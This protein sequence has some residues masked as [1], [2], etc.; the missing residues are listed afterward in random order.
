MVKF[1]VRAALA[2]SMFSI[3]GFALAA[4]EQ[5]RIAFG[6]KLCT[7]ALDG[8][9]PALDIGDAG[10][11]LAAS[12]LSRDDFC[13]CVGQAY[14]A[15]GKGAHA[16]V[17][18][19][20]RTAFVSDIAFG[21][22]V[23]ERM[24]ACLPSEPEDGDG[25]FSMGE[26]FFANIANCEAVVAGDLPMEGL[27]VGALMADM[28]KMSLASEQLCS[29][30][31]HYFT[32]NF[33]K[34]SADIDA[35]S[36]EGAAYGHHMVTAIS[37]CRDLRG[38]WPETA[39]PDPAIDPDA[40]AKDICLAVANRTIEP[41]GFDYDYLEVWKKGSGLD[42]DDLCTCAAGE[43]EARDDYREEREAAD[44]PEDKR[45]SQILTTATDCFRIMWK[46]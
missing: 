41:E 26:A 36:Q 20:M 27:N 46:P 33:D 15:E 18:K 43:Y 5:Q 24:T 34:V 25:D 9:F 11:R 28:K 17:L 40:D 30:A 44:N 45:L 1:L 32:D 16:Q 29:C 4:T 42:E 8:V 10:I 31:A 2:V 7:R 23:R 6:Q 35:E 37:M 38:V 19:E 14:A 22:H 21:K 3:S 13:G 12:D 39:Q